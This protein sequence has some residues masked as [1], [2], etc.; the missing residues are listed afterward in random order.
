MKHYNLK[1]DSLT[2]LSRFIKETPVKGYFENC[3]ELAS[4]RKGRGTTTFTKT[5]SFEAAEKLL[6]SGYLEGAK[7]VQAYMIRA[8]GNGMK[9]TLYND[10][11]G[12]APNVPNYISGIPTNMLNV[13]KT[14]AKKNIIRIFYNAAV[15]CDIT[16]EQ[17]ER[18][19]A[20]L[21]NVIV[22]IEKRGCRVELWCG[23]LAKADTEQ[24]NI[25]VC[26]KQ[27]NTPLNV[28]S[29][30]YAVV[31]PSFTRRHCFA[32]TE[33]SG[34]K[35]KWSRYGNAITRESDQREALEQLHLR[36]AVIFNYYHLR[37]KSEA[38]IADEIQ[39]QIKQLEK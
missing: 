12:F 22:G 4:T 13:K 24:I 37:G 27:A 28:N 35:G 14:K 16:T 8:T 33:R 32:V 15:G 36:D 9:N 29:L 30:A 17:I 19:A 2:A 20:S 6:T 5:A 39:K 23:D 18:A 7:R 26:A 31:H 1:F 25:A 21:F 11:V 34:A 10:F 38:K 3:V